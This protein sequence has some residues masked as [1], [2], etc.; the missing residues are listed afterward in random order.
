[1]IALGV[2]VAAACGGGAEATVILQTANILLN[3]TV[4]GGSDDQFQSINRFD[5]SLGTLTQVTFTLT[6]FSGSVGAGISW[7]G[8]E[9]GGTVAGTVT[10]TFILNAAGHGTLFSV[11]A[12]ASPSCTGLP[13]SAG[14]TG[15]DGATM[16]AISPNPVTFTLPVDLASFTGTGTFTVHEGLQLS[17]D[18]PSD[19]PT[20][21]TCSFQNVTS[22][23]AGKLEITYDYTP[24]PP[25]PPAVPVPEPATLALLGGALIGLGTRRRLDRR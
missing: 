22:S 7:T 6:S 8:G 24:A 3:Q 13:N 18:P 17:N 4:Q 10:A 23:A 11:G 20:T 15:S 12:S 2:G 21:G 14:C 19:C 1:M 25:P 9:A 16:P 5:S